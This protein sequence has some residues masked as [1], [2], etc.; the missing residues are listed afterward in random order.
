MLKSTPSATTN[1][2]INIAPGLAW[3][4]TGGQYSNRLYMIWTASAGTGLD[5][6][7]Q[8]STDF[9]RTWTN[10]TR[11]RILRRSS[12]LRLLSIKQVEKL[13]HLIRYPK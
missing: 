8:Y 10:S 6:N 7:A 5:I 12:S 13:Y 11:T 3:D 9:G 1:R 4:R 2:G